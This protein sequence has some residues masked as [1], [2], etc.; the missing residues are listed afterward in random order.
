MDAVQAACRKLLIL[1]L[2]FTFLAPVGGVLLGVGLSVGQPAIWA[3]GIVAIATFFYGCPIAWVV[4]GSRVSERRLIFAIVHENLYTEEELSAQLGK[5]VKE[6]RGMIETC[7]RR[8]YLVGYK[9]VPGGIAL[10]EN[11]NL[12]TAEYTAQ[13]PSCGAKVTFQGK[14]GRCPYCGT[15]VGRG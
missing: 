8:G 14:K 1:S 5:S 15:P 10:N 7:F 13:C 4:Y 9:R 6:V 2:L 3:I 12:A 11:E